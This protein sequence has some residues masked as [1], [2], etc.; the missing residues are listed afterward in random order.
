MKGNAEIFNAVQRLLV[1]VKVR[2]ITH[3]G[4][5]STQSRERHVI[6]ESEDYSNDVEGNVEEI[7]KHK[8]KLETDLL[9]T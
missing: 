3:T 5:T 7:L 2:L 9:I 8:Q 1:S 6:P 4:L